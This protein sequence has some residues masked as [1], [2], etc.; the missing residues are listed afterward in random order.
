MKLTNK[1][2]INRIDFPISSNVRNTHKK[3]KYN[4]GKI[5]LKYDY[6]NNFIFNE[7]FEEKKIKYNKNYNNEQSSSLTFKNH[8][9]N[10]FQIIKSNFKQKDKIIEIGC[11]KGYFF[12][13]L[14]KKYKNLRG[15]DKTYEGKNKK[16]KKRYLTKKDRID[17]KLI[18]LRHTLEHIR[19]PYDFLNFLRT[20]ST[21]N[22]YILIE[23]PDFEWKK[24]KQTFFDITYEQPN[25]FT[26]KTLNNLFSK[27]LFLK[28]KVF[29]KQYL[30]IM[31]KL[32]DL[33]KSYKKTEKLKNVTLNELFPKLEN[34]IKSF[35]SINQNIF[36]WGAAT[37]GLM[38][39]IY[40]KS[41][42]PMAFK[43]VR[44]AID[45]DKNKQNKFLQIVNIKIINPKMLKKVMKPGDYII[46]SNSNYLSEIKKYIKNIKLKKINYK[47]LD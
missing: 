13:I 14:E 32:N 44:F 12:K 18:I 46:V 20:I 43:N 17:E 24:R 35:N 30:L 38:F 37:K 4:T 16:I 26:L 15:F 21:N 9:K 42:N 6:V 27:K 19:K 23:A 33:N 7:A 36:I 1:R 11:G 29:N 2:N 39:L 31:A 41:L 5:K 34:K 3:I 22:P 25:Y 8:L 47:C 40:L 45:I 10:I 28:K